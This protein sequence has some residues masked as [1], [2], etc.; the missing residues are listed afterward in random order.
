MV[1]IATM[2]VL[3]LSACVAGAVF[4]L[5]QED[6]IRFE[7]PEKDIPEPAESGKAAVV[8]DGANL[9]SLELRGAWTLD[10]EVMGRMYPDKTGFGRK[11]EATFTENAEQQKRILANIEKAMPLEKDDP[12]GNRFSA[13]FREAVRR[14]YQAGELVLVEGDETMTMAYA[15]FSWR[16]NPHLLLLEKEDDFE[17]AHVM[18]AP[19][20]KG[21]NDIL[22]MGGDRTTESFVPLKRKKED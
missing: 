10:L 7:I 20:P 18:I 3:A 1:R 2:I 13:D 16:G 8:S 19:D 5:A 11:F 6:K 12:R 22:F 21:D 9:V 15:L 14:I 17:S 4:V